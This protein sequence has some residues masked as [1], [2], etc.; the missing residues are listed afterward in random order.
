MRA[1]QLCSM[2]RTSW[3]ADHPN[4]KLQMF[5]DSSRQVIAR[6]SRDDY[7]DRTAAML[8]RIEAVIDKQ[9]VAKTRDEITEL[10][11]EIGPLVNETVE[12]MNTITARLREQQST[13]KSETDPDR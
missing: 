10:V 11:A 8:D 1:W 12:R 7:V 4:T 9:Y 3:P 2:A 6:V 5:V 13:R